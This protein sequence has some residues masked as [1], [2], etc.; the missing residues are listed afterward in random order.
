MIKSKMLDSSRLFRIFKYLALVLLV[1]SAVPFLKRPSTHER[2]TQVLRSFKNEKRLFVADYLESEVDGNFD[3][4]ELARLCA[5]KVWR[6]E[7]KALVLTCE[8]VTGGIGAVKNG[9]LLC[10]RFSIEIG[11]SCARPII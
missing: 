4:R 6:P 1:I 8:P 7:D 3:G 2:Y 10:I 11:G 5:S 9:I